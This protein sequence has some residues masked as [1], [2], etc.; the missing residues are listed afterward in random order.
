MN[1]SIYHSEKLFKSSEEI[2]LTCKLSKIALTHIITILMTIFSVGYCGKTV[3]FGR[4]SDCHRT[5]IGHFLNKG[6]WNESIIENIVKRN[7]IDIIYKEPKN[8]GKPIFCVINN[9]VF[10]MFILLFYPDRPLK[11][12]WGMLFVTLFHQKLSHLPRQKI[13]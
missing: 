10:C 2:N 5:T 3:D 7:V 13:R 8:T 12:S 6:K 4:Q 9:T 1:N 11:I